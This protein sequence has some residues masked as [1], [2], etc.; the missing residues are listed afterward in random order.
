MR[1]TTKGESTKLINLYKAW[2][3]IWEKGTDNKKIMKKKNVC[4]LSMDEALT[5]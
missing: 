3:E 4:W 1:N 5:L 2:P